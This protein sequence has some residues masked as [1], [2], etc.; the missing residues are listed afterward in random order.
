MSRDQPRAQIA[1]SNTGRLQNIYENIHVIEFLFATIENFN[2]FLRIPENQE[3][4]HIYFSVKNAVFK[5]K[6]SVSSL[7]C[8]NFNTKTYIIFYCFFLLTTA[9]KDNPNTRTN[10]ARFR[11]SPFRNAESF[12][13]QE[14]K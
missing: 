4:F 12:T 9:S 13:R 5:C 6:N 7:N 3:Y 14:H 10:A 1:L 8:K 11:N 2:Y